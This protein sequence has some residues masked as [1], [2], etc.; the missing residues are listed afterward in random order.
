[1]LDQSQNLNGSCS[2]SPHRFGASAASSSAVIAI[3]IAGARSARLVCARSL[4]NE[5]PDFKGRTLRLTRTRRAAPIGDNVHH[6]SKKRP[7]ILA[8]DSA[9][10]RTRLPARRCRSIRSRGEAM[11]Q[12]AGLAGASGA[13]LGAAG[14]SLKNR[15]GRGEMTPAPPTPTSSVTGGGAGSSTAGSGP[16]MAYDNGAT[17]ASEVSFTGN[18]FITRS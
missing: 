11:C 4:G 17:K 12:R 9:S 14:V 18:S 2:Q 16:A 8:R 5:T 1:M 15:A 6:R 3:F 10:S 7:P 13:T